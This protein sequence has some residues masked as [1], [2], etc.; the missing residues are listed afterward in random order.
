MYIGSPACHIGR[1]SY[2]TGS[3]RAGDNIRFFLILL[4][5]EHGM[6]Q[7]A[8]GKKATGHL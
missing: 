5:V 1:N 8:L 7:S 3:A 4:R 6:L 2:A